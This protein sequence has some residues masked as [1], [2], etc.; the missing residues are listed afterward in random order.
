M[1]KILFNFG[2][3]GHL[4]QLGGLGQYNTNSVRLLHLDLRECEKYK[5][6]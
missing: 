1:Q 4:L 2:L 5:L 3:K 6:S